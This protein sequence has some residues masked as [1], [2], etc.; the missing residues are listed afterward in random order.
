MT[1]KAKRDFVKKMHS[2]NAEGFVCKNRNAVYS[3]DVQDSISNASSSSRH[4]S[5][6]A[7][8]REEGE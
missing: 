3:A 2:A 7:Q 8:A 4:P 1:T 5:S 6:L